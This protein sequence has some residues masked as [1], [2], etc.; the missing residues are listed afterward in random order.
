MPKINMPKIENKLLVKNES[1]KEKAL[2]LMTII[3]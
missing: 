2:H 1:N 3:I